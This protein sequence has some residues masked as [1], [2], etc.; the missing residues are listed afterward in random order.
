MN[1]ARNH[2]KFVPSREKKEK[3]KKTNLKKN[4]IGFRALK[5][6]IS[7]CICSY[8]NLSLLRRISRRV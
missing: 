6:F 5:K 8:A 2:L 7:L 3:K 1:E 4:F